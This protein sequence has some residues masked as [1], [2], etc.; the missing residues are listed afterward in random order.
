MAKYV[1]SCSLPWIMG[2]RKTVNKAAVE[3]ITFIDSILNAV[4]IVASF[5]TFFS[6]VTSN[7]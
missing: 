1:G 7:W 3:I 4:Y 2:Y 5:N 6:K